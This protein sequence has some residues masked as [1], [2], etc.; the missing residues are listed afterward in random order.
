VAAP[1]GPPGIPSDTPETRLAATIQ[2]LYRSRGRT[3]AEPETAEAAGI[4]LE[5]VRLLVNGM[6]V[7]GHLEEG[8]HAMLLAHLMAM[9][10]IPDVL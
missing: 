8:A 3:L 9:T 1:G 7:E 5:G 10:R 2:A 4:A 6:F